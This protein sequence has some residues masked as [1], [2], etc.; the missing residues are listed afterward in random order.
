ML[1]SLAAAL[2]PL[3]CGQ[4]KQLLYHVIW[5]AKA[6]T[7]TVAIGLDRVPEWIRGAANFE[8]AYNACLVGA[9]DHAISVHNVESALS[10]LVAE[11]YIAPP[12]V[13]VQ[14]IVD[15]RVPLTEAPR[16]IEKLA[17]ATCTTIEAHA[18]DA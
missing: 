10:V 17:R 14:T 12:C 2:S 6:Q 9:M 15:I 18:R 3:G 5:Q 8:E 11:D 16:R 7:E 4:G 1:A 13:C